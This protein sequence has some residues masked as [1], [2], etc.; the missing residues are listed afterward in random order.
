MNMQNPCSRLFVFLLLLISTGAFSQNHEKPNSLQ[1]QMEGGFLIPTGK[2]YAYRFRAIGSKYLLSNLSLGV[3]LGTDNY[4]FNSGSVFKGV[5]NTAPIFADSRYY[6]ISQMSS[7]FVFGNLGYALKIN[8]NFRQGTMAAVGAGYKFTSAG[9]SSFSLSG[10]Y[11]FQNI[12]AGGTVLNHQ[13]NTMSIN[14]GLIL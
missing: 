5:Y 9:K 14:L 3:G 4:H 13:I 12:E 10:G 6:F 1:I 11:N 8:R 2:E 7:P